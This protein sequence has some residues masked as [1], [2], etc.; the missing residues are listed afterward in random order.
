MCCGSV[1]G[2][3]ACNAQIPGKLALGEENECLSNENVKEFYEAIYECQSGNRGVKDLYMREEY[4]GTELP[5]AENIGER[6]CDLIEQKWIWETSCECKAYQILEKM[7]GESDYENNIRLNLQREFD[8]ETSSL[9]D[10]LQLWND[11][12]QCEHTFECDIYAS[13]T[14]TETPETTSTPAPVNSEDD[15]SD[16]HSRNKITTAVIVFTSMSALA[17]K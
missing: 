8:E 1:D 7:Y 10:K 6:V 9:K 2:T 11:Y 13:I 12:Y 16:G 14:T 15:N 5:E 3:P 17:F 4:C